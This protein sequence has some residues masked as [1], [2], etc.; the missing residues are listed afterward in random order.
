MIRDILVDLSVEKIRIDFGDLTASVFRSVSINNNCSLSQ[1]TS[2]FSHISYK[3]IRSCII[4]LFQYNLILF[5]NFKSSRNSFIKKIKFIIVTAKISEAI[6]RIRYPRFIS[7]IEYDYG[8]Y[9]ASILRLI[10]NSGQIYLSLVKKNFSDCSRKKLEIIEDILIHIARDGL[11]IPCNV[12]TKSN[13]LRHSILGGHLSSHVLSKPTFT[14]MTSSWK[15]SI[16][17]FNFRFKL[18]ILF[19][20]LQ[21]YQAYHT[22]HVLKFYLS[23]LLSL[24]FFSHQFVWFSIDSI[25]DYCNDELVFLSPDERTILLSIENL[26]FVDQFIEL[27]KNMFKLN[28]KNIKTFFCEKLIENLIINQFGKKFGIVFKILATKKICEEKEILQKSIFNQFQTKMILYHMHRIG[29]IFIEDFH[30][31]RQTPKSTRFW[32]LDLT[33]IVKKISITILKALYNLIVRQESYYLN[34]K[35]N[36]KAKKNEK[37]LQKKRILFLKKID[38]LKTAI[39]RSDEILSIL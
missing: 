26:G 1:I 22:K 28:L 39:T 16:S 38:T 20:L 27:K 37:Y 29:F 14:S 19:S 24:Q 23:K 13:Y 15:I 9:A 31:H 34:I 18:N 11:I 21:E 7:L 6:Y 10:L 33:S 17:M 32:K 36:F 30:K 12:D 4:I 2:L 8:F 35:K 5:E 25:P 3:T